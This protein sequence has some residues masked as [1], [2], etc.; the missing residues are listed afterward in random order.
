MESIQMILDAVNAQATAVQALQD[1]IKTLVNALREVTWSA[2]VGHASPMTYEMADE[3]LEKFKGIKYEPV[4]TRKEV[5]AK[6][7]A[8]LLEEMGVPKVELPF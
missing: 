6:A 2:E 5:E 7:K 8:E 3:V 4:M 1:D